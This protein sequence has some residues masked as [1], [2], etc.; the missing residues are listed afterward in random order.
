M[1]MTLEEQKAYI[2]LLTDLMTMHFNQ[3]RSLQLSVG[4]TLEA[5]ADANGPA[6]VPLVEDAIKKM[7]AAALC[8]LPVESV[9]KM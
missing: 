3:I 4:K 9:Y 6:A 7:K 8:A 1:P 2:E 5:A